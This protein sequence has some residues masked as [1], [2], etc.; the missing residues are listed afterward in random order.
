M[1]EGVRRDVLLDR[2]D[3]DVLLHDPPENRPVK[4]AARVR[5]EEE[6][7]LRTGELRTALDEIRLDRLRSGAGQGDAAVAPAF[8][9]HHAQEALFRVHVVGGEARE[10]A[11]ADP[12]GV[13]RFEDR[14]VP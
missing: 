11:R 9:A 1:P 8:A 6:S 5:D 4:V 2:R 7:R 10:L 13:E 14:P 12:G 3:L